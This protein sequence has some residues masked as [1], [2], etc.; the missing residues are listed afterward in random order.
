MATAVIVARRRRRRRQHPPGGGEEEPLSDQ[1]VA[2]IV[3]QA[4]F[5]G[6]RVRTGE[7]LREISDEATD[8]VLI[9]VRTAARVLRE[10]ERRRTGC[11]RLI[12]YLCYLW[13][14]AFMLLM[15]SDRESTFGLR[16]GIMRR[17]AAVK[18]ADGEGFDEL[19]TL[20]AIAEWVPSAALELRDDAPAAPGRAAAAAGAGAGAGAPAPAA[21]APAPAAPAPAP[22]AGGGA[23][24]GAVAAAQAAVARRTDGN[25][26]L[27]D[28]GFVNLYNRPI[29]NIMVTMRRRETYDYG[30]AMAD[31]DKVSSEQR[32]RVSGGSDKWI[33]KCWGKM[34]DKADWSGEVSGETYSWDE[35]R[36]GFTA[37]FTLGF[38]PFP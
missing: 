22:A 18:T 12:V 32:Q 20:E 30:C 24:T 37:K 7:T 8:V 4:A 15:V 21:P 16:S 35:H 29:P 19:K 3:I 28:Y 23:G 33:N 1:E 27:P 34:E 10:G 6:F 26:V 5:R 25:I 14:F 9:P 17:L 36:R 13:V 31:D 2:I 38:P 11:I